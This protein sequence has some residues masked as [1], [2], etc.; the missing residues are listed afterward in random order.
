[1]NVQILRAAALREALPIKLRTERLMQLR[2]VLQEKQDKISAALEKDLGKCSFESWVSE[3]GFLRDEIAH[4]LADI[5]ALAAPEKVATPM[6]LQPGSSAIHKEPYGVVLVMA[7]WN[8]PVQ[9]ALSPLI[10]AIAA[11]NRVVVKPSELAPACA[12]VIEE[13]LKQV[14]KDDE[15]QVVQGGVAETQALLKEK[16]DYIFFTGSTQVGKVVMRAAAEHLTPVTLELGGKSPC[17]IDATAPL[18]QTARR[19]AWGKWLNAGQTCVA[20]DYVLIPRAKHDEFIQELKAALVQFY[21]ENPQQSPDYGRIIN[22]RHFDRLAS[23][24]TGANAA[25]GGQQVREEKFIAPTVL[26]QVSWE[27]A[28]MQEEIF[29]PL[30]PIIAYDTIDEA[31]QLIKARPKPLAFYLFSTDSAVQE[32]V[33]GQVSFGGGCVNDTIV[34]LANSRL[35]FGG[36]GESGMG[37]YHGAKSFETFSHRKSV[38]QQTTLMDV[39]LRYPP[40]KGKEGI[41]KFLVG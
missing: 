7:P 19:V 39:P 28:L 33:L 11:G 38:F 3:I 37:A 24:M 16:F 25:I 8:Y 30:L 34:H 40:Y 14:F 5:P 10:G 31:I 18:A 9:L 26:T 32:K 41:L 27:H 15:V 13:V 23:L 35:P 6:T 29:G 4:F 17:L 2:S 12:V 1:M 22:E 20:P 21:G 36:V